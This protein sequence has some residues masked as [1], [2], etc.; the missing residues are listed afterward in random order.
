MRLHSDFGA[1]HFSFVEICGGFTGGMS[2]FRSGSREISRTVKMVALLIKTDL[3]VSNREAGNAF[4][5][6]L[7]YILGGIFLSFMAIAPILNPSNKQATGFFVML[8]EFM[9]LLDFLALQ[10]RLNFTALM[11]NSSLDLFPISRIR[12]MSLRF[13]TFLTEKRLLFYLLPLLALLV[14][15]LKKG[16]ITQIPATVILYFLVY[17]IIS[18][19]LFGTFPVLRKLAD[20]FSAKTV[21]QATILLFVFCSILFSSFHGIDGLVV[22]SP[23]ISEFTEA[24]E[25]ILVSNMTGATTQLCYLVLIAAVLPIAFVSAGL[26]IAKLS[27]NLPPAAIG[28]APKKTVAPWRR[29]S[30]ILPRDGTN[31]ILVHKLSSEY[32][33]TAP[34]RNILSFSL[35][36]WRIRQKEEKTFYMI[37]AYPFLAV[38][39]TQIIS[40]RFHQPVVSPIL[41]IFFVTL[42]FGIALT[43][44]QLTQHGIQLKHVSTFPYDRTKFIYLKSFATW[45][46]ISTV[47]II[48][49]FVLDIK[50]HFGTYHLFQGIIYS[51][52][53]P[54]V[55][56]IL[57]NTFILQFNALYR[58]SIISLFII[59]IIEI[60]ATMIY[61]L[62]MLLSVVVGVLIVAGLFM[63]T[64]FLLIP[65]WGRKL[66][67]E[68]QNLLEES[69]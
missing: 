50:L 2:L 29:S 42:M 16:N 64:Y 22:R 4:L 68:F 17:V 56:V 37:L 11:E 66:S 27:V 52:F 32:S 24:M 13:V 12:S 10:S 53:Q 14:I 26:L 69:K 49:C 35:L 20:R 62:L 60:F 38:A 1:S 25:E 59:A 18:E 57:I 48:L 63:A 41:A 51:L 19:I 23:I 31:Q 39:L 34:K 58:L 3:L 5:S 6:Y 36:D 21:T 40:R 44:N 28:K 8:L 9:T 55:L 7:A 61:V 54:L 15:L 33:A 47:N 67:F 43:E 65:A 45:S 30:R 46:I